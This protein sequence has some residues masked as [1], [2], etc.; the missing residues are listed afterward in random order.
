MFQN[1]WI[2][3]FADIKYGK[4]KFIRILPLSWVAHGKF[5]T[6]VC[7]CFS[8]GKVDKLFIE[9]GCEDSSKGDQI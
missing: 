6:S 2:S 7:V 8:V 9:V 5:R 1:K 3:D 4:L